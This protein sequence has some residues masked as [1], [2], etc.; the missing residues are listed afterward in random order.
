MLNTKTNLCKINEVSIAKHKVWSIEGDRRGDVISCSSDT[1][2]ITQQGDLRDYVV[3]AGKKFWVTRQG[4]VI[5]QALDDAQF[6]YSLNELES[7][8]ED[9]KQPVRR[10]QHTRLTRPLR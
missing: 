3:G 7:Y 2:W 9:S 5:I 1:L 6:R 4:T 10:S 8:I